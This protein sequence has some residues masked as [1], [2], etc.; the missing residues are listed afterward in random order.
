[1]CHVV[2]KVVLHLRI[3]SLA[4]YKVDYEHIHEKQNHGKHECRHNEAYAL[5]YVAVHVGEMQLDYRHVARRIVG[6]EYSCH[7]VVLSV[8]IV[9]RAAEYFL[10]VVVQKAEVI[11]YVYSVVCQFE[12]QAAV[13]VAK[14]NPLV[15]GGVCQSPKEACKPLR[16]VFCTDIRNASL[17][18]PA[19]PLLWCFW[20]TEV[21]GAFRP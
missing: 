7:C 17:S 16:L 6:K 8:G 18:R 4:Q 11:G 20:E 2:Y 14:I 21:G 5:E 19:F 3:L 12:F 1:M 13:K 10:A 9:V 15:Y